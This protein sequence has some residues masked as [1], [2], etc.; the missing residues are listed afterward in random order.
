[1]QGS[2]LLIPVNRNNGSLITGAI[3]NDNGVIS[4]WITAGSV[5]SPVLTARRPTAWS[6]TWRSTWSCTPERNLT[7]ASTVAR[8][9]HAA[10]PYASTAS[11][12]AAGWSTRSRRGYGA[13]L[14]CS[15]RGKEKFNYHLLPSCWWKVR[16]SYCRLVLKCEKQL[17]VEWHSVERISPPTYLM[18]LSN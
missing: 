7:S 11:S 17:I 8:P 2:N 18:Q 12:T 5:P 6:G 16:W 9:S 14:L 4:R 1:M 3:S 10:R 13:V 15:V